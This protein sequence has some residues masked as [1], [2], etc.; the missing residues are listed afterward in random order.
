MGD[1]RGAAPVRILARRERY[2][3]PVHHDRSDAAPAPANSVLRFDRAAEE[4]GLHTQAVELRRNHRIDA[5]SIRFAREPEKMPHDQP[6]RDA[7]AA[8]VDAPTAVERNRA[9][10]DALVLH[11]GLIPIF[12]RRI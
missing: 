9:A 3:D 7:R 10:R 11:A 1:E 2:A 4:L 6:E 5:E 12:E 8:G